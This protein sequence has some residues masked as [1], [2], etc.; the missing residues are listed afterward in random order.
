MGQSWWQ[1]V[2]VAS[3]K[4]SV[5]R[6]K[7]ELILEFAR[8]ISSTAL[9]EFKHAF[10]KILNADLDGIYSGPPPGNFPGE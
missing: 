2:E 5:V 1:E 9:A 8:I 3:H 10:I 6:K 7:M 4:A